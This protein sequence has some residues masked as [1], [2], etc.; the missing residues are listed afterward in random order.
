MQIPPVQHSG[1][2]VKFLGTSCLLIKNDTTS[3]LI[4]PHFT[5]PRKRELLQKIKP[6]VEKVRLALEK[7][8][9]HHLRAVLLTHTHYDHALDAAD[10]ALLTG[11]AIIGSQSA[12][13]LGIGA[14]LPPQHLVLAKPGEPIP[15]GK[16]KITFFRVSHLPFPTRLEDWAGLNGTINTPMAPPAWFWQ[17][18]S[19]EVFALLLEHNAFRLMVHG[20]AGLWLDDV[21]PPEADAAVLSIGGLGLLPRRYYQDWFDQ[22]VRK[23][24]IRYIYLSHWD[25][26]TKPL[27]IPMRRLP[28]IRKTLQKL[29]KT[30]K[31]EPDF[32]FELFQPNHWIDLYGE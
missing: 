18:R 15:V 9:T 27:Q 29:Q 28:G 11:A 8:H 1:F 6:D 7:T 2:S 30:A 17:Y 19:G 24:G 13:N 10:T 22:N 5:R 31:N 21:H 12:V 20:S 4:D 32:S 3:L 23:P 25:D 14:G 26:F 16:F